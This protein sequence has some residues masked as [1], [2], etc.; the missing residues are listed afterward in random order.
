M[1]R[2][3]EDIDVMGRK[4]WTLFDTGS[5]NTYVIKDLAVNLPTFDLP[6]PNPVLLGGKV[7]KVVRY[8]NLVCKVEGYNVLA[9][10]RVLDE[11]GTDEDGKKIEV[12]IGALTMQEW[13][14]V[15]I[16]EKETLDMSRYPKEFVE[17]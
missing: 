11:I 15:P 12:L 10:A 13:G 1:G 4:Y 6:E 2:I 5:R 7:H 8:C 3:R 14:I 17:F 16:P 9:H